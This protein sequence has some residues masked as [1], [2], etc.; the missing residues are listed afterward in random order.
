VQP[1]IYN[2]LTPNYTVPQKCTNFETVFF[3]IISIDFADIW[4]KYSKDEMLI[5]SNI[6]A[7]FHQN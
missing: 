3:K 4:Q 7:K 5:K 2:V 1:V 6:F